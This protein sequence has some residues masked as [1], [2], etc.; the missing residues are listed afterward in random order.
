MISTAI[1]SEI[2]GLATFAEMI[3]SAFV[4]VW[5]LKNFKFALISNMM[6]LSRGQIG[7]DEFVKLNLSMALGA[8]LLIIPGFLTDIIGILLQFEFISLMISK[9][10]YKQ[11]TDNNFKYT[12]KGDD[13]VIDVEIVDN[14]YTAIK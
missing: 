11:K 1:I 3:I 8:F 10:F 13:D 2:G 9:R 7:A 12:K 6:S 5:L 14:D 4:G